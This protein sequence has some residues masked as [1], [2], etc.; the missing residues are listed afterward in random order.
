VQ[1]LTNRPVTPRTVEPVQEFLAAY[2]THP[3]AHKVDTALLGEFIGSMARAGELTRWTV[4][5]IGGGE[6]AAT[7]FGEHATIRMLKR[8][9]KSLDDRRYSSGRLMSPRDEAI[10]LDEPAWNAALEI[11]RDTW[12][13]DPGRFQDRQPPDA[14]N[15]PAI[16]RVRGLGAPGIPA[17]PDRGVLFLYALDPAEAEI[18]FPSGPP[19]VVAFAISFPASTLDTSIRVEYKVNTVLWAPQLRAPEQADRRSTAPPI[20]DRWFGA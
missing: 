7:T 6:G 19:P 9:Y 1:F 4:A 12:T 5:L 10:D 3:D 20:R 16:R 14:P 18:G 8:K 17:H 11:T 13:A 2:R 15:G